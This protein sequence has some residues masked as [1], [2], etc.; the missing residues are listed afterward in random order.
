MKNMA[1]HKCD[2]ECRAGD[3]RNM[4]RTIKKKE[5]KKGTNLN[6]LGDFFVITQQTNPTV[7]QKCFN[8]KE[9]VYTS[10]EDEDFAA[11]LEA[12]GDPRRKCTTPCTYTEC[13][14]SV[15][16]SGIPSVYVTGG[17]TLIF[18]N[19]ELQAASRYLQESSL[20][21]STSGQQPP[22]LGHFYTLFKY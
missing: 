13:I 21:G 1:D 9:R 6:T 12:E 7:I 8:S 18:R 16:F 22:F 10:L 14:L 4:E 20:L 17:H 2:L 5:R 19:V 3:A 15:F 11:V